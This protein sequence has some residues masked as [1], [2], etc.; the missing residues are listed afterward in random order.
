LSKSFIS[1]VGFELEG[2]WDG[3]PGI[4]PFPDLQLI[5][6]HSINGQT[7]HTAPIVAV[8]VGE[9]VSPPLLFEE[10]AAWVEWLRSHWPNAALTANRTNSTCGYHI[11]VSF[12]SLKAYTLLTSKV[13][14]FELRKAV[15]EWGKEAK[16]PSK[17]AFWTRVNG[18]NTFC[19]INFEAN[20]QMALRSKA[21]VQRVRYGWLNFAS[22]IHG[23]ME[24]RALPT[25]RDAEVG[26][27]FAKKY[28]SFIDSY[29]ANN[30]NATLQLA[31]ENFS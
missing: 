24:F 14:L 30:I 2:G 21:G 25:F 4:S 26:V 17:H 23:T 29:L 5:V 28:F 22:G 19:T 12:F 16:L 27:T 9:A 3:E 6:D 11:H 15:L 31:E 18:G 7:L 13:F 20:R 1:K 8:H 10:E